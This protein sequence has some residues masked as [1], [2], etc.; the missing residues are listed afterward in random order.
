MRMLSVFRAAGCFVEK[1]PGHY[2]HSRDNQGPDR[3]LTVEQV[4]P[5]IASFYYYNR[6]LIY[7]THSIISCRAEQ[8]I[9]IID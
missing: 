1:V 9:L 4:Q 3:F 7:Y 8:N 6:I 2:E 5:L